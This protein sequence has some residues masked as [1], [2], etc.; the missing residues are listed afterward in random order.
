M[1]F[2]IKNAPFIPV[3]I[4][5]MVLATGH[6]H[7][8]T[9][10]DF[11]AGSN[12]YAQAF[13]SGDSTWASQNWL[14]SSGTN[15]QWQLG[16][17]GSNTQTGVVVNQ[18]RPNSAAA[19]AGINRMDTIICV[20]GDQVGI[21]GGRVFDLRE[22]LNQHADSQ[23]RIG[24]LIQESRGGRLQALNVQLDDGQPGLTGVLRFSGPIPANSIVT[25]QLTNVTRP[26]Y[27]VRNGEYSFRAPTYS[28]GQVP[29]TLTFDPAYIFP[30]DTYQV[31]AYV[32]SGGRTIFDT[33]RPA[34]VLT[35]GNPNSAQLSLTPVS[36]GVYGDSVAASNPN[37]NGVVLTAGY[38]NYDRISQNVTSSYQRYLG[39]NPSSIELA[40]WHQVPDVQFRLT[41]LPIELMAS[42]EYF[43]RVG[44]NNLV[45]MRQVFGEVIGHT[46]SALELDQWMRRFADL[47]YSRM[48]LLRQ[49]KSVAK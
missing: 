8:L 5:A 46:P 28:S 3:L 47:R 43:D 23:G 42:Q 15:R 1:S 29:F 21:V 17:E 14:G 39:R 34:F 36:Y 48:E 20:G 4:A 37:N 40:A 30:Q 18:I 24:L 13:S 41:Q 27:I 35:R 32:S 9:A 26:Q 33:Q 38:A 31:R 49:M 6:D 25:V 12:A 45:W 11:W 10:Q 7:R 2:F 19:R 44:N 22:E 16:I